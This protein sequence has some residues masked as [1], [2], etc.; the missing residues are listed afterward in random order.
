MRAP[1]TVAG[2]RAS[3]P[4][5]LPAPRP[6]PEGLQGPLLWATARFSSHCSRPLTPVAT[7]SSP[8]HFHVSAS[9]GTG[10]KLTS[11]PRPPRRTCRPT[12]LAGWA[13]TQTDWLLP[14]SWPRARC[15]LLPAPPLPPEQQAH[16][17]CF[18][19]CGPS[20]PAVLCL[21]HWTGPL[22]RPPMEEKEHE[23]LNQ[24]Q[25]VKSCPPP[26]PTP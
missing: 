1:P 6:P 23:L 4:R 17:P 18:L 20:H 14:Y 2:P 10:S 22:R 5:P 15:P 19:C 3:S 16:L 26:C 24:L 21:P 12:T 7:P 13:L 8:Q 11:S 25:L 9:P